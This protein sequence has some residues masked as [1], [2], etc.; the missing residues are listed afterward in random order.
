VSSAG[1]MK[2]NDAGSGRDL[3]VSET[4]ISTR[5][6]H[7]DGGMEDATRAQSLRRNTYVNVGLQLVT[8]AQS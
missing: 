8:P 1:L 2:S 6:S 4:A 5:P 3:A 7:R